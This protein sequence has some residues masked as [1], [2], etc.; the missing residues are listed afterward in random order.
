ML[1]CRRIM[2]RS[3]EQGR[4][5][6]KRAFRRLRPSLRTKHRTCGCKGTDPAGQLAKQPIR[7][8]G[9]DIGHHA[10]P[11]ALRAA[12]C[13]I[14]GQQLDRIAPRFNRRRIPFRSVHGKIRRRNTALA[15][16]NQR[17]NH[18]MQR[19][20]RSA[21][22]SAHRRRMAIDPPAQRPQAAHHRIAFRLGRHG[23]G[24]RGAQFIQHR[25]LRLLFRMQFQAGSAKANTL[26]PALHHFK[27]SEF[28]GHEQ[29]ASPIQHRLGDDIADGLAFA[30]A[31]RAL[32]HHMPAAPHG[33]RRQSLAAI[34]IHHMI[35]PL[36][37]D[38]HIHIGVIG[39]HGRDR[40]RLATHQR[41]HHGVIGKAR[42]F[43]RP[44]VAPHQEF[45]E[46]E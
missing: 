39:K 6:G 31:G 30:G 24:K 13:R 33:F 36:H 3:R 19:K 28:F 5:Q 35:Q 2:Y 40:K 37:R 38:F 23:Q 34:H 44:Q 15:Q 42:V 43:L 9:A 20:A 16:A 21:N 1:K 14:A 8:G 18:L 4:A 45:G 7:I 26:Q 12:F 17:A 27:G 22:R 41:A 10:A 46:G 29:N 25:A 32:D 11:G